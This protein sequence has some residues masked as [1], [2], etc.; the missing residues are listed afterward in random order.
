MLY[1]CQATDIINLITQNIEPGQED[2]LNFNPY[3][4]SG[5]LNVSMSSSLSEK[6]TW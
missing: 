1:A 3:T 2:D 5:S 6:Q 4:C